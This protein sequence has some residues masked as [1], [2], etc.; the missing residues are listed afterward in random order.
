MTNLAMWIGTV[1][2]LTFSS[3]SPLMDKG[4]TRWLPVEALGWGDEE[5]RMK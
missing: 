4:M 3:E 2:S 1:S 5:V